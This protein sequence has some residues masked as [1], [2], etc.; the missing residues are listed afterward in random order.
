MF[1]IIYWKKENTNL[2]FILGD[3]NLLK[4]CQFPFEIII[5]FYKSIQKIPSERRIP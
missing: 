3:I 5:D 4:V 2:C 1:K